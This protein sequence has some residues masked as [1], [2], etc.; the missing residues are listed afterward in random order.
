MAP[1]MEQAHQK[2]HLNDHTPDSI[3]ALLSALG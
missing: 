2:E 3:Q 1:L